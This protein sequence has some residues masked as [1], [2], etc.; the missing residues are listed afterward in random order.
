M[1]GDALHRA[2]SSK[3]C[4]LLELRAAFLAEA[5]ARLDLLGTVGTEEIGQGQLRAA[6]LAKFARRPHAAAGGAHHFRRITRRIEA[7]ASQWTTHP[8][9]A[10]SLGLN[11]RLHGRLNL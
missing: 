3:L 10:G 11:R 8:T 9:R 7:R 4:G 5:R 2:C 1:K 6:I